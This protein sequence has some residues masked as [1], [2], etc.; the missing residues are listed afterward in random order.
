MSQGISSYVN[1]IFVTAM[2][3]YLGHTK[4]TAT[5]LQEMNVTPQTM[6]ESLDVE[7]LYTSIDYELGIKAAQHFLSTKVTVS[8]T[9]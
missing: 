4:D 3:S 5:R 7:S 2:P 9:Q 6:I 8:V 1:D